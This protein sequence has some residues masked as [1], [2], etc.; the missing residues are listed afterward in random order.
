M[1]RYPE[2]L[3]PYPVPPG[4]ADAIARGSTPIRVVFSAAN[5]VK[6]IR[7][8]AILVC[9]MLLR[10]GAAATVAHILDTN[11]VPPA[12]TVPDLRKAVAAAAAGL[13]DGWLAPNVDMAPKMYTGLA[14]IADQADAEVFVFIKD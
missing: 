5:E 13:M 9:G 10:A 6:V 12:I 7:T 4:A 1:I 11:T 14:V 2:G 3:R 8:G